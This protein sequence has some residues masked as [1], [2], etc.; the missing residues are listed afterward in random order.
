MVKKTLM[1]KKVLMIIDGIVPPVGGGGAENQVI[2]LCV[3]F[4][5]EFDCTVISPMV[6][7]GPQSKRDSYKGVDILRISYPKITILGKLILLLK[8]AFYLFDNRK[9]YQIIHAHIAGSMSAVSSV[10][11]FILNKLVIVKIT[12]WTEVDKGI[13]SDTHKYN[14]FNMLNRY[15][16]KLATHMHATSKYI[17]NNLNRFGFKKTQILYLPNAV[18]T[19]KYNPVKSIDEYRNDLNIQG[20]SKDDVVGLYVGR[21]EPEK[22]IYDFLKAWCAVSKNNKK[23]KLIIVGSGQY[24]EIINKLILDNNLNENI[25]MLGAQ[26]NIQKYTLAVNF[27]VLPSMHEGLSNTLLEYMAS[28]LPVIGTRVSGTEDFVKPG[29]NGWIYDFG[30]DAALNV[31]LDNLFNAD[32]NELKKLGAQSRALMVEN[33]SIAVVTNK[34]KEIYRNS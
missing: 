30:D 4:E 17:C 19:E 32:K 21:L 12:G 11:G 5:K 18:N 1:R 20:L 13:L 6:K 2:T 31:I 24:D 7:F 27:G 16:I 8:L 10:M 15:C 25:F 14:I 22:G 9:D 34:F 29:K 26:T 33:A 28:A 23:Y 3:E